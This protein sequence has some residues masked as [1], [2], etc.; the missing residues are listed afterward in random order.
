[1]LAVQFDVFLEIPFVNVFVFLMYQKPKYVSLYQLSKVRLSMIFFN[2]ADVHGLRRV[3]IYWC[4]FSLFLLITK[5]SHRLLSFY[6]SQ[7]ALFHIQFG[8]LSVHGYSLCI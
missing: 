2:W 5:K 4:N 1:M 7:N 3:D 6:I 8:S